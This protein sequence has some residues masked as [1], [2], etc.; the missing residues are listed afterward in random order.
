[1]K[2]DQLIEL[3]NLFV[4]L[5]AEVQKHAVQIGPSNILF[6][7]L[8]SIQLQANQV[9][10][11]QYMT[12]VRKVVE[13]TS[14]YEELENL[15]DDYYRNCER[16]VRPNSKPP[17]S[18]EVAEMITE[19][20]FIGYEPVGSSAMSCWLY[21][22]GFYRSV[23]LE[24]DKS[25]WRK[26]FGDFFGSL[27]SSIDVYSCYLA[28]DGFISDPINLGDSTIIGSDDRR[29]EVLSRLIDYELANTGLYKDHV[30]ETNHLR[31]SNFSYLFKK[32]KLP[33]LSFDSGCTRIEA[34]ESH[35]T[36]F[37]A[38]HRA[39]QLACNWRVRFPNSFVIPMN[40]AELFDFSLSIREQDSSWHKLWE[41]VGLGS[42]LEE[43]RE[44]T[45]TKDQTAAFECLANSL[46][47]LEPE[48]RKKMGTSIELYMAACATYDESIAFLLFVFALES[49]LI[50]KSDKELKKKFCD[51]LSRLLVPQPKD[52]KP[53]SDLA[54][55]LYKVRCD[56]VHGKDS[57]ILADSRKL[58]ASVG[59]NSEYLRN[60]VRRSILIVML[61]LKAL[62]DDKCKLRQCLKAKF[63]KKPS[64]SNPS[65]SRKLMEV[66]ND[67][68]SDKHVWTEF[69]SSVESAYCASCGNHNSSPLF[70]H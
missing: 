8:I 39:M 22:S 45:L 40:G 5:Q 16:S 52:R 11:F 56:M 15:F 69:Y 18:D 34:S 2:K 24:N 61:S 49:L 13:Q 25:C 55:L 46:A 27:P 58:Y 54:D 43:Q 50:G 42:P 19:D 26:R 60:L 67:P 23:I 3:E 51:R 14:A 64:K 31:W 48:L 32:V 36:I 62:G 66:M 33:P 1:M 7:N 35:R 65:N 9:G 10:L 63:D 21:S 41:L 28:L 68:L 20:D 37:G 59:I 29:C 6:S 38:E 12:E 53:M 44:L 57:S 70:E 30:P 4:S 47:I 17:L